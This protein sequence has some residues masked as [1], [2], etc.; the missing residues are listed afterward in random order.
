MGK[1][2]IFKISK[3]SLDGIVKKMNEI[4]LAGAVIEG[5]LHSCELP[6]N[7]DGWHYVDGED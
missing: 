6:K 5:N 2:S 7:H 3:E 4:C 1:K